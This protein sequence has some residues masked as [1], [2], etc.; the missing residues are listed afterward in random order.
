MRMNHVNLPPRGRNP[1]TKRTVVNI[2]KYAIGIAILAVLI[3][4]YWDPP[5]GIG[6]RQLWQKHIVQGQP[7]HY[8]YFALAFTLCLA[9]VLQTFVRWG[10]LV[11]AIGLPFTVLDS[12]R[13]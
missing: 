11:R 6:L 5:Q 9:G 12:L 4:R 10:Y 13:L 8:G 7:V 2:F 3:W 1:V